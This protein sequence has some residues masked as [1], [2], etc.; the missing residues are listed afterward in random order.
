MG[1]AIHFGLCHIYEISPFLGGWACGGLRWCNVPFVDGV[2]IQHFAVL[3]LFAG[4]SIGRLVCHFCCCD[5]GCC[6]YPLPLP[7]LLWI[8]ILFKIITFK[9]PKQL[10]M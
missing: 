3:V 10:I 5:C 2:G 6:C 1:G 9:I 7:S 4:Q 8:T